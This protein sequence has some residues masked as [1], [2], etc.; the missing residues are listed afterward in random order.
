[1][2]T[3]QKQNS[4]GLTQALSVSKA[5][6]VREKLALERRGESSDYVSSVLATLE[7]F[8]AKYSSN[9]ELQTALRDADIK[10]I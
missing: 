10:V 8:M 1:M 9:F 7:F 5:L 4:L 6:L 3:V 2:V